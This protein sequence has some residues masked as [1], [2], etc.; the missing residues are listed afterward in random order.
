MRFKSIL[1]THSQHKQKTKFA[2]FPTRVDSKTIIWLER[3]IQNYTYHKWIE[4]EGGFWKEGYKEL[5]N[6]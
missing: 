5:I 3:Y 1:P 6:K 2:F 4:K